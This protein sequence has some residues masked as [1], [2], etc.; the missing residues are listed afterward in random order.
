MR[1]HL[2][3]GHWEWRGVSARKLAEVP[4][5]KAYP[6]GKNDG[7]GYQGYTVEQMAEALCLSVA[8]IKKCRSELIEKL[9][10]PN[11]TAAIAFA[12]QHHLLDLE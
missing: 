6:E 12:R 9:E 11:M 2:S 10:A 8:A 4:I 7:G 3:Q 5:S 1:H